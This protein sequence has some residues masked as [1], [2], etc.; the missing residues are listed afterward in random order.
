MESQMR[1][2]LG[3][4]L[5]ILVA[6]TSFCKKDTDLQSKGPLQILV[7][8]DPVTLDP[9]IPFEVDS[10]YILGNIFDSL[11]EFDGSFRL[12]PGLAKRW[13]NPDDKTWR[14]YLNEK[15]YFSDGSPLKA[16]DVAFSINRIKTLKNSDLMGFTEHISQIQVINDYTVDIK[17]DAPFSILNNLVFIPIMSE[18]Q[19]R[20]AGNRISEIPVG[21]GPYKLSSRQKNHKISLTLNEYYTPKP[22]VRQIDFIVSSQIERVLDDVLRMK[23]DITLTLPFRKIEE[24]QKRTS[25]DLELLASNGISVEYLIFNLKPNVPNF[26]KNPLVDIRLRKALAQAIDRNEVVRAIFKG[27]GRPATQLVAPEIFGYDNTLK[28]PDFNPDEAKRLVKEGGYEGLQLTIHALE[29]SSFRFENLL[30]ES[31]NKIGIHTSLQKWKDSTEMNRDLNAGNFLLA[32]GGY[33]CTSG[34]A[35]ELLSFGLHTRREDSSYGKGNYAHYS[36]LEIDRITEENLRVLDAKSRLEMIQGAMKI[37]NEEIPYLP[38]LIYD[39][40]YIVSKRIHWTPPPSGELKVRTI[41]YY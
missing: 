39:D 37:I 20:E 9:Q 36:N 3:I 2:R 1:I 13:T 29:G 7:G 31:W 25:P 17:T 41:T 24:F 40:V 34:D 6:F 12:K 27:F 28:P 11:I 23:P 18:K 4:V 22:E 5:A 10:S 21:T 15:S 16:S 35:G 19:T 33:V 32:L 38:L 8:T 14:F 30:I 26:E